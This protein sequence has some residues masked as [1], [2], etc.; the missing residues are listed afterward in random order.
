MLGDLETEE[1][2]EKDR[3]LAE[4]EVDPQLR[5]RLSL[6][7]RTFYNRK[8]VVTQDD[9]LFSDEFFTIQPL[10]NTTR[11]HKKCQKRKTLLV[12]FRKA[13]SSRGVILK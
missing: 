11:R 6:L 4:V 5:D 9:V 8:T 2:I 10:V 13:T 1:A 12:F 3:F 7:Y